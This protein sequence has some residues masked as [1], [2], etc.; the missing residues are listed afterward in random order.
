LFIAI[1][2]LLLASESRALSPRPRTVEAST[3][4]QVVW[5]LTLRE[6]SGPTPELK[7]LFPLPDFLRECIAEQDL[8]MDSLNPMDFE[9][10]CQSGGYPTQSIWVLEGPGP[11]AAGDSYPAGQALEALLRDRGL[12]N[13]RSRNEAFLR[14]HPTQVEARY[15]RLG[16]IVDK[17][18]QDW[19]A[20]KPMEASAI[21]QAPP[22]FTPILPLLKDLR[23]I[24]GWTDSPEAAFKGFN[25]LGGLTRVFGDRIDHRQP[26]AELGESLPADLEVA[27]ETDPDNPQLW[28]TW[29]TVLAFAP[30]A[31]LARLAVSPVLEG[32]SAK[33]AQAATVLVNTLAAR[34][35]WLPL[36]LLGERMVR[37]L[38]S[39]AG[40]SDGAEA[41]AL[42]TAAIHWHLARMKALRMLDDFDG[43]SQANDSLRRIAGPDIAAYR[44]D[45]QGLSGT[46]SPGGHLVPGP[47]MAALA[48]ETCEDRPRWPKGFRPPRITIQVPDGA[49]ASALVGPSIENSLL[50]PGEYEVQTFPSPSGEPQTFRIL[51]D[52]SLVVSGPLSRF[53]AA[54]SENGIGSVARL[55]AGLSRGHAQVALHRQRMALLSRIAE[56]RQA[57][58]LI[59]EDAMATLELPP[60]ETCATL[61]G[62]IAPATLHRIRLGMQARL[63][64]FPSEPTF[65][66]AWA[67][68]QVLLPE[69]AHQILAFVQS[70]AVSGSQQ[71]WHA[72]LPPEA[73]AILLP[74]LCQGGHLKEAKEWCLDIQRKGTDSASLKTALGCLR[75]LEERSK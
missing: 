28:R 37:Q 1:A 39:Q 71:A 48:S 13:S 14:E 34:K 74:A 11:S 41:E 69:T 10:L 60:P 20:K 4:D 56:R 66:I 24:P 6:P 7:R 52:G 32:V 18:F 29:A 58:R 42:R 2:T 26:L 40:A 64:S 15:L 31:S 54:V 35:A 53:P 59:A 57:A 51:V 68:L 19:V 8:V 46:V 47:L 21:P 49:A 67:R 43:L 12:G 17:V 45:L 36:S 62:R 3:P 9:A 33:E 55:T 61:V 38:E 22:D 73:H 50:L 30:D 5:R 63:S 75:Q 16:R 65:W 27:L 44:E 70:L 25:F 23:S 72:C